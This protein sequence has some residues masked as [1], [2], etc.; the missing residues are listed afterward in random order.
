MT[1]RTVILAPDAEIDLEDA[2]FHWA[3]E[4]GREKADSL[5]E[6]LIERIF[7]LERQ[8]HLGR[9]RPEFAPGYRSLVIGVFVAV[10]RVKGKAVEVLRVLHGSR[11]I[12][13]ILANP[14]PI[15]S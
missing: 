11:D 4:T 7:I 1:D 12:E 6:E 8:P 15:E 13:D 10:Y 9:L 5:L 14:Y 2:W 3:I